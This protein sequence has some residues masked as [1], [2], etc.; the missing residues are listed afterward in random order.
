MVFGIRKIR[1]FVKKHRFDVLLVIV[2]FLIAGLPRLLDLGIFLTADEKNWIGRSFEFIRAFKDWRFNDMLQTT[3][4]GVT[5]M[6]L[7]GSSVTVKMIISS[8]PFSFQN[9]FHFVAAAQFPIAL[10]NT[11][12]VPV[13]YL[14]L[15]SLIPSKRWIAVVSGFVIA[16]N[17][18]LIGYSR[19]AHVDAL[20]A[21]FMFAAALAILNYATKGFSRKWLII[22]AVLSSLAIL[23]KAPA[24]FL[25]PYFVLVVMVY[26]GRTLLQ[27][28]MLVS[29]IR[30]F[31]IWGLIIG[32][33]FV[34]IWPAML[35]VPDPQGNVLVL[36]RDLSVAAASPHDMSQELTIETLSIDHY[37]K[38]L[39]TR[40]T[41]VTQVLVLIAFAV[42]VAQSFSKQ[43]KDKRVLWLLF[44]YVFFFLV[45][46]TLGGKKGDRY[47][48][49]VFLALDVIA[50]FGISMLVRAWKG[51]ITKAFSVLSVAFLA[52]LAVTTISYH[53]YAI[54][55]SNPLFP[56]NLSQELG[57]GE[58]LEQVGAWLSEHAPEAV[59]ASWYPEEL[60]A[61]TS[62]Q[63]AHINAH[64][65]SKVE[66]IVMYRNMFGRA[67]DHYANDFIDLYFKKREP[68]FVAEVAGKEFAWVYEKW[69]YEE[70]VGELVPSFSVGQEMQVGSNPLIGV[71]VLVAT[72]SDKADTGSVVVEMRES[73]DGPVLQRW[74]QPVSDIEDDV[75]FTLRAPEPIRLV[76][77]SVFVWISATGTR[78][79]NA[80]TVRLTVEND[81]HPGPYV[82]LQ[83]GQTE[84]KSGDIALRLRYEVEGGEE[85]TEEEARLLR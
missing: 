46:M 4:P 47:I 79:G 65:Q 73:Q 85:A 76:G 32:L 84:N 55:Y 54:A 57:W 61:F 45:M 72:Y 30:D 23:T 82:R 22:S 17:P 21:G 10:T 9:I 37:L 2:L 29:R 39:L 18:F 83:G 48:I 59:V 3:H 36:K 5:A 42:L 69:S 70:I 14:L 77:D 64:E 62:A 25:V 41:P 63:V 15:R 24:I 26:Q 52:Y 13:I 60:G 58:G 53:P 8:I 19:V 11:L 6:W 27:K 74:Q 40:M 44:A 50:V 35:W 12:L 66:Y 28:E 80:P 49:P 33:L 68:V 1:E 43:G 7:I 56:D 67:P 38:T 78:E 75:W 31:V 81:Y 34:L 71:D 51:N 16:L 20:L